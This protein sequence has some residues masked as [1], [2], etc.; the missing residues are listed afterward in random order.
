MF[1]KKQTHTDTSVEASIYAMRH[2]R[3]GE[4]R[5]GFHENGSGDRREGEQKTL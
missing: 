3:P 2:G 5:T 4:E 1:E